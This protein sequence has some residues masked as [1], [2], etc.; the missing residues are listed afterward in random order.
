MNYLILGDTAIPPIPRKVRDQN[1]EDL[2]PSE[3]LGTCGWISPNGD[4]F[5]CDYGE[6]EWLAEQLWKAG[7]TSQKL[8]IGWNPI[9]EG[10]LHL[11]GYRSNPQGMEILGEYGHILPQKQIDFLDRLFDHYH[12]TTIKFNGHDLALK[13]IINQSGDNS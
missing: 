13:E 10:W 9:L 3:T 2:R 8:H 11:S 12:L 6:H 7:Y 4:F 1:P 5:A